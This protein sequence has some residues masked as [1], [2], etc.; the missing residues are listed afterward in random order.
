MIETTLQ[1]LVESVNRLA[2]SQNKLA[3]AFAAFSA[4]NQDAAPAPKRTRAKAE[5]T[6][7]AEAS[8]AEAPKA[9]P[10]PVAEAPKPAPAEAPKAASQGK[11]LAL[12]ADIMPLCVALHEAGHSAANKAM[13]AEFNAA[14]VSKVEEKHWP[15]L[16][17]LACEATVNH[18]VAKHL[19]AAKAWLAANPRTDG[20]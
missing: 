9:A 14:G 1:N 3:E 2:E 17:R 10:A 7:A 6:A 12:A 18:N 4:S 5:T 11:K 8:V 16:M 13:A 19:E 15:A 20:L